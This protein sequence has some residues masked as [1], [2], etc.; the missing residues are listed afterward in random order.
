VYEKR[1]KPATLKLSKKKLVLY[2]NSTMSIFR[3]KFLR[4]NSSRT[5]ECGCIDPANSGLFSE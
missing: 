1:R 5:P 3:E 4:I 2:L